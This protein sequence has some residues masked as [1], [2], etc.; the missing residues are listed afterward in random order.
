M[1]STEPSALPPSQITISSG[2]RVW[3]EVPN[4]ADDNDTHFPIIGD[5]YVSMN[6]AT[7]G[8]IGQARSVLVAMRDLVDFARRYFDE[9]LR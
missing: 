5:Q 7:V 8:E 6:R 9:A 3:V 4:V 2:R 1:Y